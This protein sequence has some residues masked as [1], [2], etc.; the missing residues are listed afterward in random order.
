MIECI[1]DTA[2]YLVK[3][4]GKFLLLLLDIFY[5]SNRKGNAGRGV[6]FLYRDQE[7][8]LKMRKGVVS[9]ISFFIPNPLFGWTLIYCVNSEFELGRVS[10]Y[11]IQKKYQIIYWEED[12][13]HASNLMGT[14]YK[15]MSDDC[16][17]LSQIEKLIENVHAFSMVL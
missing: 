17:D 16:A 12:D 6:I 11:F 3:E 14:I 1:V 7:G 4:R 15:K 2:Y 10:S 5:M 9:N 8:N 13:I